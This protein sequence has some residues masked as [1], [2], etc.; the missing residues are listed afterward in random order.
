MMKTRRD[1]DLIDRR[2]AVYTEIK[3]ELSWLIRQDAGYIM[4]SK[5]DN[6][7]T[8]RTSVTSV[9]YDTKLLRLIR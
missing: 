4:K 1:N 2:G 7:V 6:D 9:K 3:I 5:H 8:N